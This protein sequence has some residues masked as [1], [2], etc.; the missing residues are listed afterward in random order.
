MALRTPTSSD[1]SNVLIKA[2]QAEVCLR[3]P[4]RFDRNTYDV[5]YASPVDD[6]EEWLKFLENLEACLGK[7][8][9][10]YLLENS[11]DMAKLRQ[12]VPWEITRAQV[13]ANLITRRLPVDIPFTHRG[14][15]LL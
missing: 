11:K 13:Y 8:K 1:L 12:L 10:F 2:F 4:W 15:A 5:W 14:A 3:C 9:S 6:P 7:S